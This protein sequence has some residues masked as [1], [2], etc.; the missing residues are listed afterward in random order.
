MKVMKL[1]SGEPPAL[2]AKATGQ[3]WRWDEP[4]NKD[5]DYSGSRGGE[6][7]TKVTTD[8]LLPFKSGGPRWLQVS[9]GLDRKEC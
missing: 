8:P 3:T 1:V 6:E 2:G 7:N 5:S 4:P 9:P